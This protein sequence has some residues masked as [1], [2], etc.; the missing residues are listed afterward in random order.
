MSN[1]DGVKNN[2][3]NK[4]LTVCRKCG[5]NLRIPISY[6]PLQVTCPK[7]RNE[8]TYNYIAEFGNEGEHQLALQMGSVTL[9]LAM[10]WVYLVSFILFM[11]GQTMNNFQGWGLLPFPCGLV[12][13]LASGIWI[14]TQ[15]IDYRTFKKYRGIRLLVINRQGM[16][17]FDQELR[18]QECLNWNEV[19]SA[20][21]LV[22]RHLFEGLIETK[23]E[24]ACIELEVNGKGKVV[25]PPAMFFS[26]EQRLQIM[27]EVLRHFD[28][29]GCFRGTQ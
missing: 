18:A 24:P 19:R 7:C 16:I 26:K 2:W 17:Y 21:Y 11:V 10:I 28:S 14:A 9:I 13:F 22:A 25:V 23:R 4:V 5:Q 27:A 3:E 6:K 20:R 12:L 15:L 1:T 8:F 29:T